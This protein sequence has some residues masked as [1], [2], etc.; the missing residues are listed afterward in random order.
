MLLKVEIESE[1]P[2]G[3]TAWQRFLNRNLRYPQEAVDQN[4]EGFVTV[5]FIVDKEGNVS[6]V[7]A[8]ER[9]G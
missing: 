8:V 3:M 7:E 4:V 5:Q 9:S 2:G 6:E 1:Y